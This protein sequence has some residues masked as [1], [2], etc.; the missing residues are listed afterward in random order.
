[1]SSR[2]PSCMSSRTSSCMSSCTPSCLS[3]ICFVW[4]IFVLIAIIITD[5]YGSDYRCLHAESRISNEHSRQLIASAVS[6]NRLSHTP[7]YAAV[8]DNPINIDDVETRSRTWEGV[9]GVDGAGI[10]CFLVPRPGL[11]DGM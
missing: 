6:H 1:M 4:G 11:E 3:G 10:V 7:G 8:F 5:T 9:H 2:T